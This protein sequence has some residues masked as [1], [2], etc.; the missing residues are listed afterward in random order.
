MK[1]RTLKLVACAVI[2]SLTLSVA[3][4]GSKDDAK[5]SEPAETEETAD[6]QAEADV[7]EAEADV[8]EAEAEL[9]NAEEEASDVSGDYKTLEDYYND[10]TVKSILDSMFESMGQDGM[11]VAVE[12]NANEFVAIIK[13]EDSSMV[14]DGLGEAL[15]EALNAQAASFEAQAAQFDEAIGEAGVCT[16]TMRYTDADDNVLAEASFKAQ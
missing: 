13:F 15:E 6:T 10:P 16:V 14:V 2:M 12:V 11:S 3:A 5:T 1:R 8:E 4:C 7:E 9:E